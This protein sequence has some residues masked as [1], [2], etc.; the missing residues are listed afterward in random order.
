MEGDGA[1][2]EPKR[3]PQKVLTVY[4][5]YESDDGVERGDR[6]GRN[7]SVAFREDDP[8]QIELYEF[9]RTLS[10]EEIRTLIGAPTFSDLKKK[11]GSS[12]MS[13]FIKKQLERELV[14][15]GGADVT[16]LASLAP[17]GPLQNFAPSIEDSP[18]LMRHIL[19]TYAPEGKQVLDPFAGTGA[20]LIAAGSLGMESWWCELNPFY[21]YVTSLKIDLLKLGPAG[22]ERL[23]DAIVQWRIRVGTSIERAKP[24]DELR[25]EFRLRFGNRAAVRALE[26]ELLSART[27]IDEVHDRDPAVARVLGLAVVTAAVRLV[28][29]PGAEPAR[30]LDGDLRGRLISRIKEELD[31]WTVFLKDAPE[32]FVI[33]RFLT[34]NAFNLR[35]LRPLALDV[36]CTVPPLLNTS[37]VP[38]DEVGAWFLRIPPI[39]QA[40]A[41]QLADPGPE[42]LGS[43]SPKRAIALRK[44][45]N[46]EIHRKSVLLA[47][48]NDRTIRMFD[49]VSDIRETLESLF[50]SGARGPAHAVR[51]ARYFGMIGETLAAIELHLTDT[52]TVILVLTDD[53]FGDVPV[54]VTN[55]AGRLL[56]MAGFSIEERKVLRESRGTRGGGVIRQAVVVARRVSNPSGY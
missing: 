49:Q 43:G 21:Q 50:A 15:R 46:G 8:A 9:A 44:V 26:H 47:G 11:A 41:R 13:P 28:R 36:I 22:R 31:S 17:S 27:W 29:A 56:E 38:S 33:P 30:A 35:D 32:R 19:T 1:E 12:A 2:A 37:D 24:A 48:L 20:T 45:L 14:R 55:L 51:V 25:E 52:A 23:R 5:P 4:Y 6:Y 39:P 3:R 16:R 7:V 42:D 34:D 40:A 54:P 53:W 18:E 10:S